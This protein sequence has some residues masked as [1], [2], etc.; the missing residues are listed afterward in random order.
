MIPAEIGGK[1]VTQIGEY[2]FSDA[3]I[4]SVQIPEGVRIIGKNAFC[5]CTSLKSV[6]LPESIEKIDCFAFSETPWLTNHPYSYDGKYIVEQNILIRADSNV[7]T[8]EIVIPDGIRYIAGGAFQG[9]YYMTAVIIPDGVTGCGE[10][11]FE[12]CSELTEITVPEGVTE[13]GDYIFSGCNKLETVSLPKTL[14]SIGNAAFSRLYS[15][16]TVTFAEGAELKE[17]PFN[18]FRG[19]IALTTLRLPDSVTSIGDFAFFDCE[20]LKDFDLPPQLSHL[21]DYALGCCF[22]LESVTIPETLTYLP[23]CAFS[24]CN[25][26]TDVTVPACVTQIG[27]QAFLVCNGLQRITV[28]NPACTFFDAA[29]TVS[30]APETPYTGVIAGYTGSDAELYA[31]KYG[32]A[33]ESLGEAPAPLCGDL[34]G[35]GAVS[36]DD[37]QLALQAYV[38]GMTG[39]ADGLSGYRRAAADVNADGELTAADPQMILHYYVIC[40]AGKEA[41][42]AELPV[43]QE[44]QADEA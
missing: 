10:S 2:A 18:S 28:Q 14:R 11:A 33:F 41:D 44:A 38:R 15:L 7:C 5:F 3:K 31:E 30:T 9:C 24:S 26:L 22:S 37:A 4:T 12:W 23:E 35:D 21:G 43:R 25:K 20:E 8:G 32:Y 39:K 17:I 1:P 16:R 40:L 6:S 36:A 27:P 29:D 19:C 34:N 13:L 42:W